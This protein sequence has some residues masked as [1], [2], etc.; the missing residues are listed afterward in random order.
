LQIWNL[1]GIRA[2][3]KAGFK[4]FGRSRECCLMGGRL[5]DEIQMDCLSTEFERPVTPGKEWAHLPGCHRGR[6]ADR[7]RHRRADTVR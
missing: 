5:R 2:Y 1:A 7:G 4:K 3:Q 6:S